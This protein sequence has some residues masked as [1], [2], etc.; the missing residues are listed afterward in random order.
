[1]PGMLAQATDTHTRVQRSAISRRTRACATRSPP[2]GSHGLLE[3]F[4]TSFDRGGVG[5]TLDAVSAKLGT[6][7]LGVAGIKKPPGWSLKRDMP[8]IRA[9]IQWCELATVHVR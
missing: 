3:P 6:V 8:S 7:R 4:D 5:K 2:R 9:T 1:M